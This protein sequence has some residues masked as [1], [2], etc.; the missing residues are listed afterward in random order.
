MTTEIEA[1]LAAVDADTSHNRPT[2]VTVSVAALTALQADLAAA[3]A[4]DGVSEPHDPGDFVGDIYYGH[5]DKST[6]GTHRWNGKEWERLK[7]EAEVLSELLAEA[8]NQRD[9]AVARAQVLEDAV[10]KTKRFFSVTMPKMNI[11]DSFL[12]GEDFGIWN[13]AAIATS[14]A[15]AALPDAKGEK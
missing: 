15:F 5:P 4:R 9:A 13:E 8:R 11:G 7:S 1:L 14:V 3:V 6:L 12:D 10:R 2:S